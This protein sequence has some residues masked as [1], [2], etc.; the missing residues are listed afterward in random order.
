MAYLGG[1]FSRIHK[2]KE[3]YDILSDSSNK[4]YGL[5]KSRI[6]YVLPILLTFFLNASIYGIYGEGFFSVYN[7]VSAVIIILMFLYFEFMKRHRIIGSMLYFLMGVFCLFLMARFIFSD[8]WSG[9]G[10]ITWF[11]SGGTERTGNP[12]YFL[13][14]VSSFPFFLSSVVYYFTVILYRPSFLMLGSLVPCAIYVKTVTNMSTFYLVCIAGLNAAIYVSFSGRSSGSGGEK[15]VRGEGAR[16]LSAIIVTSVTLLAASVIPKQGEAKYY[17][18]FEQKFMMGGSSSNGVSKTL[19]EHSGNAGEFRDYDSTP[20]FNV[21]AE[22][23][24][25]FRRQNFDIY[26]PEEH[27]WYPLE[28]F[29]SSYSEDAA[30]SLRQREFVN[31]DDMLEAMK[32]GAELDEELKEKTPQKILSLD[33][34]GEKASLA[35]VSPIGFTTLY[36]I[37][38][39]RSYDITPD[40]SILINPH[41]ELITSDAAADSYSFHYYSE[42]SAE[43]IWIENGGADFS[44]DEAYEEYLN[45]LISVLSENGENK[46]L[47]TAEAFKYDYDYAKRYHAAFEENN[48][49]IPSDLKELAEELTSGLDS[50]YQKAEA[51][52]DFFQDNFTY[53]LD[54]IPPSG[55]NTASYFVF[56]S[57]RGTCSDFATA[58]T[59]MARSVGLIVRYTEGFS[60][61]ITSEKNTYII[62]AAGSHAYPEVYIRNT[63]WKIYEPTVAAA[64]SINGGMRTNNAGNDFTVNTDILITV[65]L[66]LC[67]VFA[68]LSAVYFLMPLAKY[69]YD[70]IRIR[71]GGTFSV[72]LIY[73]RMTEKIERKDRQYKNKTVNM[74][75]TEICAKIKELFDFNADEFIKIYH[76]AVFGEIVP[77]EKSSEKAAQIYKE[78]NKAAKE[79]KNN[80]NGRKKMSDI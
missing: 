71:K 72:I 52:E 22:D 31:H 56:E 24:M 69:F 36:K 37:S 63:G 40:Q 59:L 21:Y 77:D 66:T 53:D 3:G 74:T 27:C 7:F 35:T 46:L 16:F 4:I 54:Y 55:N 39:L 15:S 20:L 44:S 79:K 14:L 13:A 43:D 23:L 67:G 49:Q 68:V 28:E 17:D 34:T 8:E 62:R 1:R 38:P 48:S 9:S 33:K 19:S 76:E 32:K 50:D 65:I 2:I 10:F 25:Y 51:L 57:R 58:Y 47:K 11:Q 60:P 78:F 5:I 80:A 6:E 29:S 45:G 61:D 12:S 64:Y 18:L 70:E 30:D 42:N 41:K 26:S 73:R 75:P